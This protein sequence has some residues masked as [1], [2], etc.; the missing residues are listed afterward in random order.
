VLVV[1][2]RV[3]RRVPGG[4]P[5]EGGLPSPEGGLLENESTLRRRVAALVESDPRTAARLLEEWLGE[6][7]N[8]NG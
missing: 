6:P 1:A 5:A 4:A 3:L 7:E 8:P 2:L